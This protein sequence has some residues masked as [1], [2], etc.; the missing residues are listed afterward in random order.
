[1]GLTLFTSAIILGGSR[2]FKWNMEVLPFLYQMSVR[3]HPFFLQV[4][5][6]KRALRLIL[7]V[8]TQWNFTIALKHDLQGSRGKLQSARN[9]RLFWDDKVSELDL[10]NA[11]L[12]QFG[13][14]ESAGPEY[15]RLIANNDNNNDD[16]LWFIGQDDICDSDAD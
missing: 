10:E 3:N 9:G 13:V 8:F 6:C 11:D 1:M 14:S 5:S 12:Q 7:N 4:P 2:Q 16:S 15:A